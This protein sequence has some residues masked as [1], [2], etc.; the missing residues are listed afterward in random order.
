MSRVNPLFWPGRL[1]LPPSR[2]GLPPTAAGP[3]SGEAVLDLKRAI[4]IL[5]ETERVFLHCPTPCAAASYLE[6]LLQVVDL[7]ELPQY[8][9]AAR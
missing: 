9:E 1:P 6:A 4:H 2:P 3:F 8:P 5:D 7:S